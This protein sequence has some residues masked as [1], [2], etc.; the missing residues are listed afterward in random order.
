MVKQESIYAI[1]KGSFVRVKYMSKPTL[2]AAAKKNGT[3]VTKV[4]SV[5][6]RFGCKYSN[7]A[8]VKANGGVK[9]KE[10]YAEPIDKDN[11]IYRHK[12]TGQLYLQLEPIKS[13]G[14]AEVMYKVDGV[15]VS[16]DKLIEMGIVVP[17]Y[18][19][20]PND[21]PDVIRVKLDN[22]ISV[23]NAETYRRAV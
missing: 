16:K 8:N 3:T 5:T 13:N 20:K 14:N 7:L 19:N 4:T 21:S 1:K 12:K 11:I 9:G 15:T 10:D 17:S 18:W 6:S 23:E 2:T 22:V